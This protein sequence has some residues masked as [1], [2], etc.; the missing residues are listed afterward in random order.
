M[1][2]FYLK[3]LSGNHQGAE[4][5]LEAGRHSLGK[6]DT[7]D[8]ILTDASLHEMELTIEVSEEGFIQ[9]RQ[10]DGKEPPLPE[11]AAWKKLLNANA[12]DVITSSGLF[13][14]L[15]P[16]DEDWPDILLPEL[17]RPEPKEGEDSDADMDLGDED[18]DFSQAPRD[19]EGQPLSESEDE[20]LEAKDTAESEEEYEDD[21]EFE[22]P[23]ANINKKWLIGVPASLLVVIILIA[24]YCF[25]K[26]RYKRRKAGRSQLSGTGQGGKRRAQPEKH[27]IQRASR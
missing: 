23:L 6:G 16:A 14:T 22:N 11:R 3:I 9:I 18:G 4:I 13:F 17:P 5:P 8:L 19:D 25:P 12:F 27:Q 7:C 2:E 21:E 20:D 15:G 1:K 26:L 24:G 10:G